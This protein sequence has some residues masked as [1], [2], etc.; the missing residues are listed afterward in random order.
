MI[1]IMLR[2]HEINI[3]IETYLIPTCIANMEMYV[4]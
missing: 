3:Q 2:E 1:D 4:F